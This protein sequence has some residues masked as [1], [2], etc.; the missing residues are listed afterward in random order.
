[1]ENYWLEKKKGLKENGY[2]VIESLLPENLCDDSIDAICEFMQM[3]FHDRATWYKKTPLN[4]SGSVPMH[5]HPAFWAVRQHPAIYHAFATLLEESK[6]WVTMDRAA[7]KVPCRY[8]LPQYG[9]DKNKMHWDYDVR[10]LKAPCYQG[11]IY[12]VDTEKEQGAF[13]CIPK[14]YKKIV[15]KQIDDNSFFDRSEVNGLFLEDVC[16]FEDSEIERISAPKGS[17]IIFDSRLPHGNVCTHHNQPRFVQFITMYKADSKEHVPA[18]LYQTKQQ[19][20]ECYQQSRPPE[21]LRGWNGQLDPEP[22]S[23]YPLSDLGKK[24]VGIDSW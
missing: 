5:H 15:N 6:L 4:S 14:I 24:L 7:V 1:M 17:L 9:N 2:T 8:D 19:R 10:T 12:L 16:H 18:L 21:W 23:P 3:D 11:L 20:I 13:G 22:H